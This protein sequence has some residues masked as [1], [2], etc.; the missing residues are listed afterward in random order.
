[1]TTRVVSL[2]DDRYDVYIGRGSDWGNPYSHVDSP[3]VRWLVST[4]AEAIEEYEKYVREERPDLVARL[5][6]LRGK[7]LGCY[8]KPLLG[9]HGDVLVRL[10]REK[11]GDADE[12][13][14]D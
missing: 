7:T 6:E 13:G 2:R 4:R 12:V 10:V 14:E 11:F 1:M 9:C 5:G 3:L 8:C